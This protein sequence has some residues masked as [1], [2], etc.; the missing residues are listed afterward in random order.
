MPLVVQSG[1]PVVSSYQNIDSRGA[2]VFSTL[3]PQSYFMSAIVNQVL[4]PKGIKTVGLIWQDQVALVQAANGIRTALT[5][6]GITLVADQ[7]APYT[8]TDLSAQLTKVLA[9]NP[10]AIAIVPSV[11]VA[12]SLVVQL[13]QR[14]YKGLIFGGES[15]SLP[16]FRAA[17]G[18]AVAGVLFSAEWDPSIANAG[19]QTVIQ[20]Y[21]TAY[22]GQPAPDAFGMSAY[23]ATMMLYGAIEAAGSTDKAKVLAQ[24]TTMK[25]SGV[26]GSNLTF[27]PTTGFLNIPGIVVQIT[28]SGTMHYQG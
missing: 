10:A 23:A 3:D 13:R 25:T 19:A 12:G 26:L 15:L 4:V 1:L 21:K 24:L 11:A 22:P 7:G 6:A 14:N 9:A 2:N 27:D 18:D 17:A 16:A 8:T 20:E 5:S 28:S